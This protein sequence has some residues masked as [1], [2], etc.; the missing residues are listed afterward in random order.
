MEL[1][2]IIL[3]V[4]ININVFW[5]YRVKLTEG[6]SR[7]ILVNVYVLFTYKFCENMLSIA[8]PIQSCGKLNN[9]PSKVSASY[10]WNLYIY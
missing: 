1:N 8:V 5:N 7:S 9:G 4:L 2:K 10:P 6:Y 3:N